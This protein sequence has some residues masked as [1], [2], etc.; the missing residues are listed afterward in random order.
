M[1]AQGNTAVHYCPVCDKQLSRRAVGTVAHFRAH[2]RRGEMTEEDRSPEGTEFAIPGRTTAFI[3]GYTSP[4]TKDRWFAR[5]GIAG[6][7]ET[8]AARKRAEAAGSYN[9]SDYTPG[10][11][12]RDRTIILCPLCHA[13]GAAKREARYDG[14]PGVMIWH[15]IQTKPYQSIRRSCFTQ[16]LSA[17]PG[18]EEANSDGGE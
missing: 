2:V 3:L 8:E 12:W 11:V 18:G 4:E 15:A 1:A 14:K 10:A 6:L 5:R 16:D 13:P 9:F 7:S 17:F